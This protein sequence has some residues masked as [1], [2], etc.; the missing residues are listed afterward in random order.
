MAVKV[1]N[2]RG[3]WEKELRAM[4]RAVPKAAV[5]SLNRGLLAARTKAARQV[6]PVVGITV[7]RAKKRLWPKKARP[8]DITASLGASI[9]RPVLMGR[10]TARGVTT[11]RG[12]HRK[13]HARAWTYG[14][15]NIV[16]Q[17]KGD[18][19]YP[20]QAVRG[21]SV[22]EAWQPFVGDVLAA[23]AAA[24][25]KTLDHEIRRIASRG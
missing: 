9:R 25:S 5:R 11:G 10:Q 16:L 6:A 24:M 23:A 13:R 14:P 12:A 15:K 21:P 20:I 7:G 1:L 22:A 2:I 8:G 4:A 17:R 18:A 19:R 3:D